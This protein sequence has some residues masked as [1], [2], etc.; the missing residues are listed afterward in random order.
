ML[1]AE[2]VFQDLNDFVYFAAVVRHNGFSAAGRVLNMP[3][4][5]LSRHITALETRLGV[6]LLER[7]VNRFRVT[8]I[9]RAFYNHCENMLREAANPHKRAARI[10]GRLS[11]HHDPGVSQ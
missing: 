3:K 6:R 9:G 5:K 10:A 1:N 4:S 2:G 11:W 7:T 8:E